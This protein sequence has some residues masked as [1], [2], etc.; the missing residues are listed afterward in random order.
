MLYCVLKEHDNNNF[1]VLLVDKLLILLNN[2]N[3]RY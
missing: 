3:L 1:V 2:I